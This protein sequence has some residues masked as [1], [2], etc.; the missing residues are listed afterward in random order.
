MRN[1]AA[2]A[3]EPVPRRAVISEAGLTP[4]N[5]LSGSERSEVMR[6]LRLG[7]AGVAAGVVVAAGSMAASAG[8]ASAAAGD[9]TVTVVHGIPNTPVDVYANGKKILTG[10]KFKSVAGPLQLPAGSYKLD[11]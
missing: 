5:S 3:S 2:T 7:V 9:A 6:V 11:V 10:F 1:L 8:P 4:A